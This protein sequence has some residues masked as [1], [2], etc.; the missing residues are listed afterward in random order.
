MDNRHFTDLQLREHFALECHTALLTYIGPWNGHA[1]AKMAKLA[2]E[3]ADALLM[4]L[5]A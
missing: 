1:P 4:E 5:A 3:H 2:I